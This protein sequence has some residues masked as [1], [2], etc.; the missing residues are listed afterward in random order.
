MGYER[1]SDQFTDSQNAVNL[2][3]KNMRSPLG[4]LPE[5]LGS[6]IAA[7]SSA[8]GTGAEKLAP[9]KAPEATKKVIS[10]EM[11][12]IPMALGVAVVVGLFFLFR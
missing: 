11:P 12:Y 7:I 4:Q 10:V 3:P 5:D 1:L 6:K 9:P 8:V 2:L